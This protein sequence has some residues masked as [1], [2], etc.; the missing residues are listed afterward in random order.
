MEKEET[1][2][3]YV[4]GDSRQDGAR[5]FLDHVHS[6]VTKYAELLSVT[7]ETTNFPNPATIDVLYIVLHAHGACQFFT[8]EG[9]HSIDSL[10]LVLEGLTPS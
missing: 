4:I 2:K 10:R 3:S 8:N 7:P 9:A 6:H 5:F 1:K